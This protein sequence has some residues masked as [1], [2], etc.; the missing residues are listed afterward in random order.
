MS[1]SARYKLKQFF[2]IAAAMTYRAHPPKNRWDRE[3]QGW[4][5]PSA[6]ALQTSASRAVQT[7]T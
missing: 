2:Q 7:L 1:K 5:A 3:V 4:D 6:P